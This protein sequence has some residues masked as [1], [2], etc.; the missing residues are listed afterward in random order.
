M[1]LI[2]EIKKNERHIEIN[3]LEMFTFFVGVV[4]GTCI[5]HFQSTRYNSFID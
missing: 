4:L 3:L 1:N 5:R 2:D